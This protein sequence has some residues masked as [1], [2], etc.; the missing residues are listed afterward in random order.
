MAREL[1]SWDELTMVVPSQKGLTRGILDAIFPPRCPLCDCFVLKYNEPCADCAG[2][3]NRID[4]VSPKISLPRVH[5]D[6]VISCFAYEGSVRDLICGFKFGERLDLIPYLAGE[7][8]SSLASARQ[9]DAIVPVPMHATKIRARGFNPASMLA[10]RIAD[11][12][13]IPMRSN[14]L[15]RVRHTP[16]QT[17]LHRHERIANIRG[18]FALDG[19][20]GG[21]R[22]I[23]L[24][25]DV[26]T[27]GATANE[28]TT[29]LKGAGAVEVVV[30]TVARTL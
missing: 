30:G 16:A 28:C 6:R 26:L 4:S 22:R 12:L 13:C 2:S 21:A 9:F 3:V 20:A 17:D 11:I 27:T 24:I 7:L 15:K 19:D 10:M 29:I 14:S 23:L 8:A 1:N 25:D 18:A 5:M